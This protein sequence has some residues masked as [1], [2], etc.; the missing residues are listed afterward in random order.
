MTLADTTPQHH[1]TKSTDDEASDV[2]KILLTVLLALVAWGISIA[3]WGVPGLYLPA[4]ALTPI[5][6]ILLI[7]VAKG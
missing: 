6:Y 4:V 2:K 7:T 5:M 3:T 1:A